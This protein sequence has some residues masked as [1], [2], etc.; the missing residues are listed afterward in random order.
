MTINL[1]GLHNLYQSISPASFLEN[2]HALVGISQLERSKIT[3]EI[4][5]VI[6]MGAKGEEKD[7]W[8]S[9]RLDSG[10]IEELMIRQVRAKPIS[11]SFS[12]G[13]E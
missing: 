10:K 2:E 1:R 4:E 13:S 11:F 7:T 9:T 5:W 8:W 12:I 6:G 3:G